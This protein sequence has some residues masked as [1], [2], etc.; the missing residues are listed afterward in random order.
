[1]KACPS[2]GQHY[3]L[4]VTGMKYD[5]LIKILQKGICYLFELKSLY[6]YLHVHIKL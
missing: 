5:V 4:T 6:I 1:M 3:I 2:S